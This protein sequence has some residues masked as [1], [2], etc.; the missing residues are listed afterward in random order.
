MIT[1]RQRTRRISDLTVCTNPNDTDATYRKKAGKDP[2][3]V[4][5]E[6]KLNE[7]GTE[8]IACAQ[9]HTPISRTYYENTDLIRMKMSLDPCSSCPMREHC[10][11]KMQ[12][13]EAV[14]LV[15]KK[16]FARAEY[17]KKLGT[18]EYNALTRQRNAV[19]GVMS[20]L[21]RR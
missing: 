4:F 17:L 5:S 21:R 8:F 15:S 16:M 9:G 14:V 12:K 20:V 18:E 3:P 19:E 13:K 10:Q 2:D 11:A 1:E 6:Y 7:E